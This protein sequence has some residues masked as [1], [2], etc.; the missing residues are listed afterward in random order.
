MPLEKTVIT[1]AL[2]KEGLD[3]SLADGLS[4]ETEDAMNGWIGKAKNFTT[5]KAS[6]FD[7]FTPEQLKEFANKRESKV[8]QS[9]LDSVKNDDKK[10]FEE[11]FN[12]KLEESKKNHPTPP[13]TGNDDDL[14]KELLELKGVVTG[15]LDEKKALTEKQAVEEKKTAIMK[16]LKDAGC[17]NDDILEFVGLK[18]KVDKD[19]DVD[20]IQKEGKKIY[21]EKYKRLYG[22]SYKPA[23]GSNGTGITQ[24]KPTKQATSILESIKNKNKDKI[25]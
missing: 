20:E 16:S 11:E 4:F 2:K 1:D 12:K 5:F 25:I 7:K 21:D 14:K 24:S 15:L 6:D 17:D 19:S 23:K 3:E 22:R 10:K 8:L 18:I 9:L 13:S